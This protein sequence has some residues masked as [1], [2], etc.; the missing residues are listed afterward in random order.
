MNAQDRLLEYG[1]R[2]LGEPLTPITW[3]CGHAD[4]VVLRASSANH[5]SVIIK[6]HRGE[7][8]HTQ[9]VRAY[10][11]WL[12]QLGDGVPRLVEFGDDPPG[13]AITAV[14]GVALADCHLS[15][16]DEQDAYAAA[17]ALLAKLHAAAPQIHDPQF[18]GWL[19]ERGRQWLHRAGDRISAADRRSAERKLDELA[20]VTPPPLVPCHLDLTPRNLIRDIDGTIRLI[21]FE[22]SRHDL[23]ARDLVRL[24]TR[25][26]R[27]RPDLEEAFRSTYGAHTDGERHLIECCTAIDNASSLATRIPTATVISAP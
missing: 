9:E 18:P 13:I 21:D 16:A 22:H 24:T 23:A 20:D 25:V 10:Q 27:Q 14:P 17:G 11:D 12:P 26:W 4:T 15:I 2:L 7:M 1:G 6:I 19:A 3:H 5:P 8:R